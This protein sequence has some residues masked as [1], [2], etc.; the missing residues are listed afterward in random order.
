MFQCLAKPGNIL[1]VFIFSITDLESWH[2]RGSPIIHIFLTTKLDMKLLSYYGWLREKGASE[3][4]SLK[5]CL[6]VSGQNIFSKVNYIDVYSDISTFSWPFH[7]DCCWN[8]MNFPRLSD[9]LIWFILGV[10]FRT[11]VLT[12]D[13]L[14]LV[15]WY[16]TA[17]SWRGVF[18][19]ICM[20]T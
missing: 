11:E 3:D 2:W 15:K 17:N 20:N 13:L 10:P 19:M 4:T 16:Q 9:N 7:G 18:L 12:S 5:F 14:C 1:E 6:H 8:I